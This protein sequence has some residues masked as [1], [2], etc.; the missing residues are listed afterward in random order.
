MI[1]EQNEKYFDRIKKVKSSVKTS[2][3]LKHANF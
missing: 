3:L 1:N 2:S